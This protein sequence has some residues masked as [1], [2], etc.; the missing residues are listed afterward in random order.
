MVKISKTVP[1]GSVL[2]EGNVRIKK[3]KISGTIKLAQSKITED[4]Q[5]NLGGLVEFSYIINKTLKLKAANIATEFGSC[6][7]TSDVVFGNNKK[8]ILNAK[9]N[10]TETGSVQKYSSY[11]IGLNLDAWKLKKGTGTVN[12]SVENRKKSLFSRTEFKIR[13]FTSAGQRIDYLEGFV[14]SKN[15]VTTGTFDVKDKTLSGKAESYSD[16]HVNRIKFYD[17]NGESRKALT[18]LGF[19]IDLAGP[20]KGAFTF[21]LRPG[22]KY[23]LVRG[24]FTGERVNFYGFDFDDVKGDLESRDY[25]SIKNLECLYKGGKGNIDFFAD[26]YKYKYKINGSI[27]Q[28]DINKMH[29]EFNGLGDISFSGEGSF[30][31]KRLL[32]ND[33]INVTYK[34]DNVSF[35]KDHVF[36]VRGD[37]G[38]FTDFSD[39]MIKPGERGGEIIYKIMPSPFSV[40]FNR[41]RGKYSGNF[42]IALKDINLLIPWGNNRGEMEL[43]GQILSGE[44]GTLYTEGYADFKGKYLSFPNFPHSLDNFAG[45]LIFKDLD[46]R[47]RS[48]RGTVG[49][50][51]VESSGYLVIKDDKLKDLALHFHGKDMLLYPM[52]RTSCRLSTKDL[53]LKYIEPE[54]K[55]LLAGTLNFST[56]AW[57]RELDEDISFGTATSLSSSGSS[58][59]DLLKF[60]LK[61]IGRKDFYVNNSLIKGKG[62]LDLKLTGTSEFP[63]VSGTI[64]VREGYLEMADNKFEIIKAKASFNKLNNNVIV[65]L[66]SETFIK[67]YRIKFNVK[68]SLSRLKPEFQSTPPLP[69]RDILTLL[70]LGELF[71]RPTTDQL[72]SQIGTGTTGL[73]A[74]EITDQIK[75]RTKK[76]FGDYV[77]RINPNITSITGGS[78]GDTSQ[79]IVGKSIAKDILI[80]YSTN[81]STKR[82]EILYV[83]YQISP[84]ISLIGM[85]NNE[86][87]TF[88][89]DIRFRKRH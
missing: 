84:T 18:I 73:I 53:T 22:E 47:L 48:L 68:G 85:R 52:D 29:G 56:A 36:R 76:I 34:S 81:F 25:V 74:Q 12:L 11:Y 58:F 51:E 6:S 2:V 16:K 67:N 9:A 83:Q 43:T 23:P 50:G 61:L 14:I 4:R 88:S 3:K 62:N 38:I 65:D 77:L 31:N 66:E 5:F 78:V 41:I 26:F 54:D 17:V 70:S 72:S 49:G 39:F 46:F 82:Q 89:I 42:N 60:D 1:I 71:V 28:I 44:Q 40:E 32:D 15:G 87:N 63:G 19:D 10:V 59:I 7:L 20:M 86:E 33:P 21:E 35:Y 24:R 55:V 37:A 69:P 79:V 8:L 57:E 27:N 64:D 75:K 45:N 13:D 80:V 30:G